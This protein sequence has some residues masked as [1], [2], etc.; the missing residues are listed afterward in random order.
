MSYN[1]QL[2][3]ENINWEDVCEV[4]KRAGLSTK[5]I[6]TTQK[7]FENSYLAVFIFDED[8]LIGTGRALSDGAYQAAI[9]DIAVLPEYQKQGIGKIIM[10]ELHKKLPNMNIILYANPTAQNF[11]R[12]LGY[13]KMLT[14]MAKYKNEESMRTRGFID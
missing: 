8:K 12:R 10:E 6:E 2:N 13:S 11:Y 1:I 14:G 3:S 9:Y 4:I 5:S 7:A